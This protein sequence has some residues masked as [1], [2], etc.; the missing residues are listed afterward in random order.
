MSLPESNYFERAPEGQLAVDVVETFKT[1]VITTAIAGVRPEDVHVH[2]THDVVTIRGERTAPSYPL[3]ATA[4]FEECFWGPFSRS[5]IL[6][7]HI[8]P[9][10]AQADFTNGI[11]TLTLPK[12]V[13][14]KELTLTL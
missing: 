1:I 10:G 7:H 12:I 4:H 9:D 5:I 13:G 6:P 2:I 11:L 14:E 8:N 3:D